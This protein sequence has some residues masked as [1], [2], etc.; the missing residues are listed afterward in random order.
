MHK[1]SDCVELMELEQD[2]IAQIAQASTAAVIEEAAVEDAKKRGR[3]FLV[4]WHNYTDQWPEVLRKIEC[5]KEFH[6]QVEKGEV[7]GKLHVQVAIQ[8]KDA[9]TMSA[10]HKS[11]P[12]FKG[13]FLI[14]RKWEAVKNYCTKEKT[15]VSDPVHSNEEERLEDCLEDRCYY[16]WQLEVANLVRTRAHKDERVIH[17]YWDPDG[18]A[19]KTSFAFHMNLIDEDYFYYVNSKGADI[20]CAI[21]GVVAYQKKKFKRIKLGCVFFNYVRSAED[22]ISYDALESIKDRIFFN[23]KYESGRCMM[24]PVHVICLANFE[25]NMTRCSTDRWRVVKITDEMKAVTNVR[26]YTPLNWGEPANRPPDVAGAGG[27]PEPP[28]VNEDSSSS[29]EHTY[30]GGEDDMTDWSGWSSD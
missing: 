24:Q 11:I 30:G 22:Y 14:A 17:W 18:N 16:E 28:Q 25:P 5:I 3:N 20:K 6:G 12:G 21:A 13:W 23:G 15:R 10:A 27:P 7:T 26:S 1:Q 4:T 8:F 2:R 9:K 29:T 19:G